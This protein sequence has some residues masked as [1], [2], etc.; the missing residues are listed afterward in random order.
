MARQ[1]YCQREKGIQYCGNCGYQCSMDIDDPDYYNGCKSWIP[2]R[3]AHPNTP[4]PCEVG[5]Y[6]QALCWGE[7]V[8]CP[9]VI[10]ANHE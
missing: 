10:G 7:C 1:F 8:D 2:D 3:G 6:D 4:N 5:Y 9:N